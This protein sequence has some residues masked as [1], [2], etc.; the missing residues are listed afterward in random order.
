M[1][2][3]L[4]RA[5]VFV[6]M[7]GLILLGTLCAGVGLSVLHAFRRTLVNGSLAAK[8]G[9][10]LVVEVSPARWRWH[11]TVNII[12]HTGTLL[13]DVSFESSSARIGT[14]QTSRSKLTLV[15]A[16]RDGRTYPARLSG[17]LG[18]KLVFTFGDSIP[19]FTSIERL[20][21]TSEQD[22]TVT[23]ILWLDC[24]PL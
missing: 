10:P 3:K 5:A 16:D 22:M 19:R 6:I 9:V 23:Y 18:T 21:F 12:M 1:S 24:T 8:G 20:E 11:D 2:G 14:N 7:V 17:C 13:N 4:P 15:A